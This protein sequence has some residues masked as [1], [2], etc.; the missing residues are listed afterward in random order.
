MTWRAW[1]GCSPVAGALDVHVA[2]L[3][4]GRKTLG[5]GLVLPQSQKMT[6]AARAIAEKKVCGHRS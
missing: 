5:S 4:T 1:V 3:L 2:D 6:V